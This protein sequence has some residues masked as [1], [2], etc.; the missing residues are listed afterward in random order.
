V[1]FYFDRNP[2]AKEE[3]IESDS[4]KPSGTNDISLHSAIKLKG[5]Y[6]YIEKLNL[7]E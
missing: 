5:K 4:K 6:K 2:R 7:N 1:R 3:Y